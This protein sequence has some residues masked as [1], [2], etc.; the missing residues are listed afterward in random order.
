MENAVHLMQVVWIRNSCGGF[1]YPSCAHTP[2][3]EVNAPELPSKSEYNVNETNI[4][5][6]KSPVHRTGLFASAFS[7]IKV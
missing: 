2:A 1:R 4:Y 7:F 6:H 3:G 5:L